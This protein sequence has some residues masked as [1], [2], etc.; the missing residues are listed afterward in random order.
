M[1]KRKAVFDEDSLPLFPV[2][3]CREPFGINGL[4][5]FRQSHRCGLTLDAVDQGLPPRIP[6][7]RR[8]ASLAASRTWRSVRLA[9]RLAR[10]FSV[11]LFLFRLPELLDVELSREEPRL[12]R[13]DLPLLSPDDPAVS[14]PD[15]PAESFEVVSLL[16]FSSVLAV[17]LALLLLLAFFLEQ[18]A[19]TRAKM[20]RA[21]AMRRSLLFI[22]DRSPYGWGHYKI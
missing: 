9:F 3:R 11:L 13:A 7:M 19:A 20:T 21:K 17:A 18:P 2:G 8:A 4:K 12:L 15:E 10:V 14:S 1:H 5:P 6:R 16:A 22:V